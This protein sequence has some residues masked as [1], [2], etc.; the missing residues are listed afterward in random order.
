MLL[1]FMHNKQLATRKQKQYTRTT[2]TFCYI[3][4]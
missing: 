1:V 4:T 3:I 2:Y